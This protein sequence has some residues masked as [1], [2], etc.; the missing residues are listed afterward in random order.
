MAIN[1]P[2]AIPAMAGDNTTRRLM[3]RKAEQTVEASW[4]VLKVEVKARDQKYAPP[5]SRSI[6]SYSI[7]ALEY[8][9]KRYASTCN[10]HASP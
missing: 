2:T 1:R 10:S 3:A 8:I 7:S 9:W 6:L 4:A 5:A